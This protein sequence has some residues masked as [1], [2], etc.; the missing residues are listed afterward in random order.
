MN[1]RIDT[2]IAGLQRQI[3]D[4][5]ASNDNLVNIPE[6][7]LFNRASQRAHNDSCIESCRDEIIE[8]EKLRDGHITTEQ[9]G[10]ARRFFN[11]MPAWAT[12]G[13]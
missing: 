1:E 4:L 2:L 6:S 5:Q 10:T 8:L 12:Y 3:A 11:T 9:L 7:W 13:T